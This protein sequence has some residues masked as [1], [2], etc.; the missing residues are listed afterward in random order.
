[1]TPIWIV[2]GACARRAPVEPAPTNDE[3]APNEAPATPEET[4]LPVAG[5][6]AWSAEGL[7]L[8]VP[9]GWVGTGGAAPKV[10]EL[11][12]EAEGPHLSVLVLP[13]G[14]S[15]TVDDPDYVLA[16]ENRG[17]YR[18]VPLIAPASLRTWQPVEATAPDRMAW[19]GEAGGRTIAVEV[20]FA[21][22]R[23][24]EGLD[25]VQPLLEGLRLCAE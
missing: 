21:H 15:P 6:T 10:L 14:G 4:R 22:G 18:T 16:F 25:L 19:W 3:A 7:C 23:T 11:Q 9:S 2:L 12:A 1:M 20:E 17:A 8:T 13:P 5:P 24:T